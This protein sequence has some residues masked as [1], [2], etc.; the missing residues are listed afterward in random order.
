MMDQ[1]GIKA[2]RPGRAA[3]RARL[4]T[5]TTTRLRRIH[6]PNL[7]DVLTLKNGKKVTSAA[8]WWNQRRPEIVEDFEREVIGRIPKNVPK[9]TWEVTKSAEATGGRPSGDRQAASGPCGQFVVPRLKVDI[10]MTLVLPADAKGPVPVMM[11]FGGRGIPEIAFPPGPA[12]RPRG[13]AAAPVRASAA[14]CRSARDAATDRGW[15]G[16]AS[17]NPNSIQ[18]DNG[19]GLTKGIIGLVNKGQPRKPDDWGSLRAWGWGAS[20]ASTIWKP[21]RRWTPNRSGSKAFRV[22]A[23]P[24]W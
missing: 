8:M 22:M 5:P 20:R 10:Q 7:P 1:L 3:M 15:L 2:L 11:M 6:F 16:L 12:G 14:E 19:A 18:A 17:I 9:V 24:R 13:H 21:R 4:T 23:K